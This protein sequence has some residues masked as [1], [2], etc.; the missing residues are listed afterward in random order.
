MV[1]FEADDALGAA[2]AR[3]RRRRPRRAGADLHARQGPG[4]VRRRHPVV[5]LDRRQ[6]AS[7]DEAGV[8]EKFG[9]RPESI[10][11]YLALVGDTADGFPG[12]PGLGREV[13]RRGARRVRAPRGDPD[14]RRRV[15]RARAAPRPRLAET[16]AENLDPRAALSPDRDRRLRRRRR[17]GGQLEV[18]RPDRPLRGRVRGARNEEPRCSCRARRE[19]PVARYRRRACA[20]TT[21]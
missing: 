8:R 18:E 4:A 14:R 3:R 7:V 16:L 1:E 12:L 20:C 21:V 11:D 5:Q 17:L 13:G 10:P 15:G 6:A 19:G 2:A 9:V